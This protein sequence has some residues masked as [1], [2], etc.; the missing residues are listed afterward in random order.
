[1]EAM[2]LLAKRPAVAFWAIVMTFPVHMKR[3]FGDICR[4]GV[5]ADAHSALLLGGSPGDYACGR[6]SD[7]AA[8]CWSDGAARWEL[9][10][11]QGVTVS[12]A[13]RWDGDSICPNLLEPGGPLFV[14]RGG[15]SRGPTEKEAETL[16]GMRR[17]RGEG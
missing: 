16:D 15:I 10:S 4:E 17:S 1:V 9:D 7:F 2:E 8:G 5:S 13:F 14:L 6:D 12:Q 3:S 11:R